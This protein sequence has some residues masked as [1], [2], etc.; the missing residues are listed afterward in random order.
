MKQKEANRRNSLAGGVKSQRGKSISSKN[1]F[2]H[3]VL[4]QQ[5]LDQENSDY[6]ALLDHLNSDYQPSTVVEQVLKERV[7]LN[8]IQLQRLNRATN[9]FW[10]CCVE[11]EVRA[12]DTLFNFGLGEII[13][14]GYKPTIAHEKVE[15]M[16]VVYHRYQTRLE[17][18]LIKLD[19]ELR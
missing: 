15:R 19:R 7:A 3:G 6:Q 18:Q 4:S 12:D 2:K 9:E 13:D 14:E 11:P 5:V 17:N 10:R 1:A 16:L 8:I